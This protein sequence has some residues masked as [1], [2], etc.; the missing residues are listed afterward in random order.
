MI[1]INKSDH[2][3]ELSLWGCRDEKNFSAE[4]QKK[5]K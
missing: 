5:N 4:P 1:N 2:F 3:G